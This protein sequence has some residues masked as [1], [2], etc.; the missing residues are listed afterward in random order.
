MSL[1]EILEFE[2][3]KNEIITYNKDTDTIISVQ[4]YQESI[5]DF[6]TIPF[7]VYE[8]FNPHLVLWIDRL[9][10]KEM[11]KYLQFEDELKGD[12]QNYDDGE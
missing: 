6:V 2:I 5:D 12:R 9:I 7:E 8:K 4:I 3:N 1:S 10:D 11:D